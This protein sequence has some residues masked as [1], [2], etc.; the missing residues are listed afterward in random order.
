MGKKENLPKGKLGRLIAVLKNAFFPSPAESNIKDNRV[1]GLWDGYYTSNE[2]YINE[3]WE[4]LIWPRIQNADFSC[5]VDLACGRGRNGVKL[6]GLANEIYFVD[7]NPDAIAFCRKRF[8]E[9]SAKT[10]FIVNNGK[11]LRGI[12]DASVTLLYSWDSMVHFELEIIEDYIAEFVRIMKPGATGLIH[13]SN[14]G[15]LTKTKKRWKDNPSWRSHVT[16]HEVWLL[17]EKYGLEVTRQDLFPWDHI[18]NL[19]CVTCF[20]KPEINPENRIHA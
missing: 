16:G 8:Q 3:Q 2:A 15:T 5:V 17:L 19:D 12:P 14:Y 4:K 9:T 11:D 10:H 6:I 18:I 13:H 7:I 20:R 1:A